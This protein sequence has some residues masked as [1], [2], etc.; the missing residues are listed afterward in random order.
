MNTPNKGTA[1][2]V[3]EGGYDTPTEKMSAML[4]TNMALKLW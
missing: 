3:A 2:T 4:V 1:L